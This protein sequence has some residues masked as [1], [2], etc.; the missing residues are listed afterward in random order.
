MQMKDGKGPLTPKQIKE[1]ADRF[2]V[3]SDDRGAVA[4]LLRSV[5]DL[6]EALKTIARRTGA[7]FSGATI[8]PETF[9]RCVREVHELAKA[10]VARAEGKDHD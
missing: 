3:Y 5:P 1:V 9:E 8:A 7:Q 2:G 4:H 6:L 10:A